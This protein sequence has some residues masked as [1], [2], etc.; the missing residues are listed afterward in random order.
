ME[1]NVLT[2]QND[3][4][5]ITIY[6]EWEVHHVTYGSNTHDAGVTFRYEK[7]TPIFIWYYNNW[8]DVVLPPEPNTITQVEYWRY[9][10]ELELRIAPNAFT[11]A[12]VISMRVPK[13]VGST[14][15][16]GVIP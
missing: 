11:S 5:Y 4:E 3:G 8:G 13:T 10:P 1:S 9:Y 7:A 12:G 14:L 2:L 16:V 6:P 15:H